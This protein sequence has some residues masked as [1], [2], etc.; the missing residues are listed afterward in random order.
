[1]TGEKVKIKEIGIRPGEKLREKLYDESSIQETENKF[2]LNEKKSIQE[3]I[4][5]KKFLDD[6]NILHQDKEKFKGKL[7]KFINF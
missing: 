4:K 5:I 3:E 6:L 7:L 1:M 2:I